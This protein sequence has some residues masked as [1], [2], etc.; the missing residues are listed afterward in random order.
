MSL[1]IAEQRAAANL[2]STCIYVVSLD[3][4]WT[5]QLGTEIPAMDSDAHRELIDVGIEMATALTFLHEQKPFLCRFADDFEESITSHG[6]FAEWGVASPEAVSG[7]L[8]EAIEHLDSQAPEE[9]KGLL[10]KVEALRSGEATVGDLGP[11]TRGSLKMISGALT[12]GAGLAALLLG[13]DMVGGVIQHTCKKLG[14]TLFSQG[15][16]EWRSSDA[17]QTPSAPEGQ[18]QGQTDGGTAD[19]GTADGDTAPDGGATGQQPVGS[20]GDRP[21]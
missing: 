11:K 8:R 9:I 3:N 4:T 5:V 7:L 20:S 16:K 17:S 2:A 15:L 14:G 19:G 12:Y 6:D 21:D 1:T 10:Y 18:V 13:D